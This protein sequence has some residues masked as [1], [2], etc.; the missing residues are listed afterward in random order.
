MAKV[1]KNSLLSQYE[2]GEIIFNI[3]DKANSLYIIQKGQI[4]LFVPKGKGYVD[5]A[6]L[7]SGEVI[8]EMAIL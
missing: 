8:G 6:I 4:R 3:R 2:P 5:L 1:G 7:R